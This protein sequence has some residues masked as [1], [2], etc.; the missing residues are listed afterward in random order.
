MGVRYIPIKIFCLLQKEEPSKLVWGK[1]EG[2]VY[3][4]FH[5]LK[6]MQASLYSIM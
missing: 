3:N 6:V 2:D 5:L 4:N 1:R